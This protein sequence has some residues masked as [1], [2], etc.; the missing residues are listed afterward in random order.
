MNELK[1]NSKHYSN[2]V[3]TD[4]LISIALACIV[5]IHVAK[6]ILKRE[7]HDPVTDTKADFIAEQIKSIFRC[8][9]VG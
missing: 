4:F 9:A 1:L 5:I 2:R 3:C 6:I 7:Y 8:L